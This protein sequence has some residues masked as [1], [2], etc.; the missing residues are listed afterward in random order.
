MAKT[1]IT[2]VIIGAVNTPTMSGHLPVHPDTIAKQAIAA[3]DAGAAIIH[4]HARN[5]ENGAPSVDPAHFE[6]FLPRLKQATD[7]VIDTSTGGNPVMTMAER[8][9]PVLTLSPKMCSLNM[10]SMNFAMHPLADRYKTWKEGW[11]EGYV[12][13]SEA[14]IFHNT[15]T[16]IRM[17]SEQLGGGDHQVIRARVL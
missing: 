11:E 12:R 3:S 7:A 14:N 13:V 1:I 9:P 10:G 2:C 8:L 16:D 6:L 5:P 15:F 17:I 4:L